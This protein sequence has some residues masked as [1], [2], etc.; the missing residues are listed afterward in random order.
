MQRAQDRDL[1]SRLSHTWNTHTP[2]ADMSPHKTYP[3]KAPGGPSGCIL[4]EQVGPTFLLVSS[5]GCES[6]KPLTSTRG[7]DVRSGVGGHPLPL[8]GVTLSR[9]FRQKPTAI[10]ATCL[11]GSGSIW[12]Q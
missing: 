9:S 10:P 4:D 2:H 3:L 7:L 12:M 8:G 1:P 6:I 11:P 5:H